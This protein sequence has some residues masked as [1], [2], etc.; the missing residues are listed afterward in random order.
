MPTS[1]DP[2]LTPDEAAMERCAHI[3][4]ECQDVCLSLVPYFRTDLGT[5]DDRRVAYLNLLLD[6][7]GICG[8]SH[9][10]L[11]RRSDS[12]TITCTACAAICERCVQA[13]RGVGDEDPAMSRCA[14]ACARCARSCREMSGS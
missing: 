3:C 12:H 13:C 8:L 14:D 1:N 11:H 10:V 7:A 5:D 4:H 9:S 2:H 6:C